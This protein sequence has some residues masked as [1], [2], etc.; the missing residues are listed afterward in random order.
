MLLEPE[1]APAN[2]VTLWRRERYSEKLPFVSG[3]MGDAGQP[4]HASCS[5]E[6]FCVKGEIEVLVSKRYRKERL[7]DVLIYQRRLVSKEN[8]RG[9]RLMA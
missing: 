9:C 1:F 7:L 2:R 5:L 6:D 3:L 4:P 8:S